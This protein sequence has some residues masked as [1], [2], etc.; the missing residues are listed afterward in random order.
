M[1]ILQDDQASEFRPDIGRPAARIT[2]K[3]PLLGRKAINDSRSRFAGK[4]FLERGISYHQAAEIGD[5][6]T[7]NQAAVQVQALCNFKAA[8]LIDYALRPFL[9]CFQIV[10]GPPVGEVPRRVKLRPLIVKAVRHFMTDY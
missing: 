8:E 4:R 9:K 3:E 1:R 7:L 5:R 2:E 10:A 6:F